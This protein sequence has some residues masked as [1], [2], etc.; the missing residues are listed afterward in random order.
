MI[1]Q[2]QELRLAAHFPLT[3]PYPHLYNLGQINW[4]DGTRAAS[5]SSR[6]NSIYVYTHPHLLGS[7]EGQSLDTANRAQSWTHPTLASHEGYLL[8]QSVDPEGWQGSN[9]CTS[10]TVDDIFNYCIIVI[11]QAQAQA[12]V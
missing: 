6:S 8:E 5:V 11:K 9:I 10:I 7:H 1:L 12:Q 4:D 3:S 2:Y